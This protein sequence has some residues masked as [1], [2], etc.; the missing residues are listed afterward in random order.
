MPDEPTEVKEAVHAVSMV[1]LSDMPLY[2]CQPKGRHQPAKCI[3][4][5]VHGSIEEGHEL[6]LVK[7]KLNLVAGGSKLSKKVWWPIKEISP[8]DP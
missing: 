2:L 8:L 4:D 7:D 3:R 1:V 6:A 5:M